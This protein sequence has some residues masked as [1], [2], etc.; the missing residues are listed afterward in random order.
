MATSSQAKALGP[1]PSVGAYEGSGS[2][3]QTPIVSAC[4]YHPYQDWNLEWRV[5]SMVRSSGSKL[6]W[7][8]DVDGIAHAQNASSTAKYSKSPNLP[9]RP[10]AH[11]AEKNAA[12]FEAS[13]CAEDRGAALRRREG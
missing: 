13:V 10:K 5:V 12:N 1:R 11:S 2:T 3:L 7:L 8:G 9:Q 4:F 6:Y